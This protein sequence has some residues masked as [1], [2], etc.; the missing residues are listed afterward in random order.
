MIDVSSA[1]GGGAVRV[2]PYS[3]RVFAS[4]DDTGMALPVGNSLLCDCFAIRETDP[5]VRRT[6]IRLFFL[7]SDD[8]PFV[9]LYNNTLF[10]VCQVFFYI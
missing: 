1:G 6:G 5:E 10:S 3:L 8:V 4:S 9:D 2:C 7:L